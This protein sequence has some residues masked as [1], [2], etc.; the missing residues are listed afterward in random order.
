MLK[1]KHQCQGQEAVPVEER[2]MLEKAMRRHELALS[3]V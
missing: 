2:N 3:W 1:G